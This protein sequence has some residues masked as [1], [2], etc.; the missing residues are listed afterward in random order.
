M[1]N[2]HKNLHFFT[3]AT[4]CDEEE[5]LLCDGGSA[6]SLCAI[7]LIGDNRN[8]LC[9]CAKGYTLN[10]TNF[11]VGESQCLLRFMLHLVCIVY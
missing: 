10:T 2:I 6:P 4:Q 8:V 3:A 9:E 1:N 5:D 7:E 11:C